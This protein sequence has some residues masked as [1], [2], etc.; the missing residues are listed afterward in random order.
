MAGISWFWDGVGFRFLSPETGVRAANDN[1]GSCVLEIANARERVL[2]PGDIGTAV[3][4]RLLRNVHSVRLLF[5]PHHGSNSSSSS[6]F[7]RI[8]KPDVVFVSAGKG[9][10]YD[11]PHLAV[12]RRYAAV[13]AELYVTGEAGALIWESDRPKSVQRYRVDRGAYW[14]SQR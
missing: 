3:E 12:V 4:R 13:G 14:T 11:H 7:V 8:M 9:N 10:R 1:D 5:A 2:L 6:A